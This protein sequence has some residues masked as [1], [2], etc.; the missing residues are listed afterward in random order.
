MR[1]LL[2]LQHELDC[3][4]AGNGEEE[5]P[6]GGNGALLY[7][8]ALYRT[9]PPRFRLSD[10][11]IVRAMRRAQHLTK[12]QLLK[13]VYRGWRSLGYRVPRGATFFSLRSAK[14]RLEYIGEI[15]R[16]VSGG[17]LD[18]ENSTEAELAEALMDLYEELGGRMGH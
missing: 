4:L 2:T 3:R 9:V 7:M 14:L 10:D 11:D 8:H 1:D 5:D 16:R 17:R 6:R 15:T 12:R 13:A 18:A